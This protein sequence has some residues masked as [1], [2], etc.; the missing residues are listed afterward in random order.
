MT[1]RKKRNIESGKVP[2]KK[3]FAEVFSQVA[4]STPRFRGSLK[5]FLAI[6]IALVSFGYALVTECPK[7]FEECRKI[8]NS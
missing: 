4:S 3:R 8:K 1:Q 7:F 5:V 6:I 2:T